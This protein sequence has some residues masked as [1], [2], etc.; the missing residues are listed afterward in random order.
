V[1]H[2]GR[3]LDLALE[4]G[5]VFDRR[6]DAGQH[7]RGLG[8]KVEHQDRCL[9]VPPRGIAQELINRLAESLGVF[10]ELAFGDEDVALALAQQDVGLAR[11]VEGLDRSLALLTRG[12]LLHPTTLV[13]ALDEIAAA[14]EKVEAGAEGK[15]LIRLD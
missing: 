15:V 14:H 10:P 8:A 12:D 5:V 11:P 2:V 4:V 1:S 13:Y 7:R 3:A 9:T 6:V